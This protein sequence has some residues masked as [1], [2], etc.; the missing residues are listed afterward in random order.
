LRITALWA[1]PIALLI[2]ALALRVVALRWTRRVGIG[3]GGDKQLARAIRAHANAIETMPIAL[4]LMAGYE[5]D[6][7]DPVALHAIGATLLVGRLGHAWGLSRHGGTSVGRFMG[8]LS[9]TI[10]V[11]GLA[12]ALLSDLLP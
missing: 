2:V 11:V 9:W 8:T 4:L 1:A 3:D 6:G 10:V 5:L 7:G 12:A